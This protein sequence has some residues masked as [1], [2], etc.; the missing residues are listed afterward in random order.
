MI[1]SRC[2][3]DFCWSCMGEEGKCQICCIPYCPRFEF[4]L[5][6]AITLTIL[7]FL[8][9]PIVFTI[10]PLIYGVIFGLIVLPYKLYGK[11]KRKISSTCGR[12]ILGVFITLLSWIFG[13]PI[14]ITIGVLVAC[15]V[16]PLATIAF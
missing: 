10:L 15:V 4:S 6:I 5:C 8:L 7:G 16:G 1:C 2:G 9:A 13:L 11:F 3:Y 12:I 14:T